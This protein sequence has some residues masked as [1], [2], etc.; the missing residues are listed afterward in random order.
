MYRK[1]IKPMLANLLAPDEAPVIDDGL[2]EN[3]RPVP[4]LTPYQKD[5]KTIQA[6]AKENPKVV[7]DVVAGWV[8]NS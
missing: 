7:A 5:L 1:A 8:G 4:K 2:D 3:G 6:L